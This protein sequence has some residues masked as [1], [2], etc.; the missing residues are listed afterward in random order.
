MIGTPQT[1]IQ[2]Y[3]ALSTFA[4]PQIKYTLSFAPISL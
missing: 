3:L 4:Y 1:N 2:N